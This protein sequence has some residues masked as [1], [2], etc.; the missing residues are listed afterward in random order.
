MKPNCAGSM[1][2]TAQLVAERHDD[3]EVEDVREIDGGKDE[4]QPQFAAG[5]SGAGTLPV[6][7]AIGLHARPREK[8]IEAEYRSET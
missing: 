6:G 3:D 5:Q 7:R 8:S 1:E 2:L 4:D